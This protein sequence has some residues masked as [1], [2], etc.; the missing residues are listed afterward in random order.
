MKI[1]SPTWFQLKAIGNNYPN[2]LLS[3]VVAL[4]SHQKK[5]VAPEIR[6]VDGSVVLIDIADGSEKYRFTIRLDN[7][8]A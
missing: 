4:L 5:C 8:E 7:E 6:E 2:T 1:P 3:D